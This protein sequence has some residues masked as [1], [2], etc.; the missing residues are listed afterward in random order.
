MLTPP[1]LTLSLSFRKSVIGIYM[2]RAQG[3]GVVR[4]AY[5]VLRISSRLS[6]RNLF[7]LPLSLALVRS[8]SGEEK[9]MELAVRPGVVVSSS[10]AAVGRSSYQ[11]PIFIVI[12][13]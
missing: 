2:S 12:D 11:N 13:F 9:G 4:I 6:G 1:D 10:L 8:S 3:P 7:T 5:G